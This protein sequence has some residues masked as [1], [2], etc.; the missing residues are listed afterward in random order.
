[1]PPSCSQLYRRKS[2]KG[3]HDGCAPSLQ[4]KALLL[5]LSLGKEVQEQVSYM[6]SLHDL[7]THPD[8]VYNSD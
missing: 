3:V 4:E 1:M 8:T 2:Q 7:Q 6:T 5:W